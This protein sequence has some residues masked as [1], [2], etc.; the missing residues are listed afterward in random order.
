MIAMGVIYPQFQ[1][2][3][4]TNAKESFHTHLNVLK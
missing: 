1:A 4:P 3:N 2:K